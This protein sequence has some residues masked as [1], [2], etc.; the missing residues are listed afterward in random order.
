M[1]TALHK[2]HMTKHREVLFPSDTITES[3]N[4]ESAPEMMDI[5]LEDNSWQDTVEDREYIN[6]STDELGNLQRVQTA[7]PPDES[8]NGINDDLYN[9]S[10][11]GHLSTQWRTWVYENAGIETYLKR[12]NSRAIFR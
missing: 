8:N 11:G 3:Y 9:D 7:T 10:T 4:T 2:H 6:P 5:D 1:R 12:C